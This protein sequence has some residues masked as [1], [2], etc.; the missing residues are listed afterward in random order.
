[1]LNYQLLVKDA[2]EFFWNTRKKQ[3]SK[4]VTN[5]KIDTWNRWAV[6][7]WQQMNWFIDLLKVITKDC[8]VPD[9]YIYTKG[10]NLPWYFRPTKNW[11]FIIISPQWKLIACIEL[12]SHVGSFGNNFNN[13]T[14]EA[15]WNALDIWTAYRENTFPDQAP[16]FVWY[17]MVAEKTAISV[18]KAKLQKTHFSVLEEFLDTSYLERYK[19]L[20]Q[21]LMRERHYTST[22]LISTSGAKHF[23]N[24]S[25]DI[26]I[27]TFL[28]SYKYYISSKIWDFN[29]L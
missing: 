8:W 18:R 28:S 6:T 15:L 2:V 13:R 5:W 29:D 14:E 25:E 21:K 24:L 16:P 27:E 9:K 19:L 20:C 4:K 1:M 11:D 22:A 12:K 26:S 3:S 7:W 10:N 23:E 17:L